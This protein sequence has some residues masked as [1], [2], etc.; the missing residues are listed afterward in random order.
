MACNSFSLNGLAP[1]CKDSAGSVKKFW[2]AL[3]ENVIIT[4]SVDTAGN[5]TGEATIAIVGGA[6]LDKEFHVYNVRKNTSSMTSTLNVS[7]TAGNSFTTEANLQFLKMDLTKRLE[8]L[9]I[10]MSETVVIVKDGNDVYHILGYDFP[11]EASAGTGETGTA[12]A[13][14]NGYNITLQDVSKELPFQ[15]TDTTTIA[16]LEAITVA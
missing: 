14:F 7:D 8:A 3:A 12:M 15:I 9:A 4:P 2:I 1:Q 16:A 11:V 10:M 6:D 5:R 13:D